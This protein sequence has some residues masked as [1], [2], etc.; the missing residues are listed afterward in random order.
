MSNTNETFYFSTIFPKYMLCWSAKNGTQE[1]IVWV[2]VRNPAICSWYCVTNTCMHRTYI[3]THKER[4][5]YLKHN[6]FLFQSE[7]T[8]NCMYCL[9]PLIFLA[10][11]MTRFIFHFFVLSSSF[12]AV[13]PLTSAFSLCIFQLEGLRCSFC[14][15]FH[16]SF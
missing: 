10:H 15:K 1:R 3:H 6:P 14:G 8:V 12:F 16:T 13:L 4:E 5:I 11:D 2:R 7:C 9:Y